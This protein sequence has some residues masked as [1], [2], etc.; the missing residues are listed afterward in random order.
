MFWLFLSK[1][2]YILYIILP[3]CCSSH[4]DDFLTF[5][6]VNHCGMNLIFWDCF[7]GIKGLSKPTVYYYNLILRNRNRN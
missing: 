2:S 5:Y 3:F 7:K 6:Y 1:R 4:L